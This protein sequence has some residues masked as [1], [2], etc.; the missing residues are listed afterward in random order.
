MTGVVLPGSELAS[1]LPPLAPPSPPGTAATPPAQWIKGTARIGTLPFMHHTDCGGLYGLALMDGPCCPLQVSPHAPGT[2]GQFFHLEYPSLLQADTCSKLS[3][4]ITP[5]GPVLSRYRLYCSRP[6]QG[7]T[8]TRL[9][10][11]HPFIP[12][13]QLKIRPRT[14]GHLPSLHRRKSRAFEGSR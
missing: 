2:S 1:V 3:S 6:P 14:G 5:S 4:G 8:E 11:S 9:C 13:T 7:Q 12:Q 10:L